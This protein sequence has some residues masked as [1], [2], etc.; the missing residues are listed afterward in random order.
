[1]YIIAY[2][3]SYDYIYVQYKV[4]Y[5]L[6]YLTNVPFDHS[7]ALAQACCYVFFH[8]DKHVGGMRT[9]LS[10]THMNRSIQ[11]LPDNMTGFQPVQMQISVFRYFS[12]HFYS[13]CWPVRK[14]LEVG[15]TPKLHK[16][17]LQF[18]SFE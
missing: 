12:I 18:Q 1:M 3:Y 15:S 5:I 13:S 6:Y 9:F 4:L 2:V 7:S 14:R 10:C 17:F 8:V 11:E 16:M